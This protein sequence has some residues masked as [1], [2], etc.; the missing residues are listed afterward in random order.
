[1]SRRKLRAAA[2]VF[3]G[4]GIV[5]WC[6]PAHSKDK[7][8]WPPIS[9]EELAM[10]DNPAS[11]GS[12]A[13]ILYRET[14][15]NDPEAWESHYYRIKVFTDAGKKYADIEIPYPKDVFKVT[16]LKARTIHPNGTVV[17][18][19]GNPFD[20]VVVKTRRVSFLA[21][22]FTLPDVQVG[23]ILEYRYTLRWDSSLLYATKW[24]VQ[25]ELFTRKAHFSVRPHLGEGYNFH[26]ISLL[27][28][29][30]GGAQKQKDGTVQMD[31]QNVPGLQE[32]KYMP[33]EDEV[34]GRV[35]FFYTTQALEPPEQFWK[36]I[37]K[38]WYQTADDFIGKRKAVQQEA[39]AVSADPPEAK[40]RK[41]YARAQQIRNLSYERS[42]SE[43]EQK[44]EKLKDNNNV[45]D[46]LKHGYGYRWEI[47]RL[48]V[49][50]ARA[51][52]FE[53]VVVP[54]AERDDNFFHPELM[55]K[56]QLTGEVA[57]VRNGAQDL[58]L[59]PGTAHCPFGLLTWE[60]TGVKGI[61]LDK[62]GG[63]FVRT[64]NLLAGDA[65]EQRKATVR[66]DEDGTLTG[67]LEIT[68][69]GQKALTRR[70]DAMDTDETGRRKA[71]KDEIKELLPSTA[72][73]KLGKISG[74]D[75]SDGPVT[76]EATVEIPGFGTSTGR[77]LLLPIA[78]FQFN[79][80]HPFSYA[81]RTYP[82]YFRY[83]FEE[84]DEVDL[85][86]PAGYQVE[87]LPAALAA[88]AAFGN[89][90]ITRDKQANHV[91][92]HRHLLIAGVIFSPIYYADLRGFY[93]KVTAG[94]GDQVVV[95]HAQVGSK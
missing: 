90:E 44:Q 24:L 82:V 60:K 58:Y 88:M 93:D 66:L 52:G 59:D 23:S 9:P 19:T 12:S 69:T 11:P 10:K 78:L 79:N 46:V 6:L 3:A 4:L 33:P 73:L 30:Y 71:A 48:F 15:T 72:E 61:K 5:G 64:P 49:A 54:V 40:L 28:K 43:A 94:D 32:E 14:I 62:D 35:A 21:K 74:L 29:G 84:R 31:V 91:R 55:D 1:M 68:Y 80:R 22:T 13:M 2:L 65:L 17:E 51:A 41:L 8:E 37:G 76:V 39:A 67:N 83:P 18:Y 36:R 27:P 56:R 38:E 70:L 81:Q 47:N 63:V 89:Y 92:L 20:K 53:A 42:K 87:S 85:E 26:W 57:L 34:K 77:R 25:D 50:L 95:Q 86:L 75:T 7:Q 45:E 16:D